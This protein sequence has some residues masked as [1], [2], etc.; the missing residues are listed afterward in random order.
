[1]GPSYAGQY[2]FE[3]VGEP[4]VEE[5]RR[6]A[7]D[8]QIVSPT[9]FETVD[10]PIVAGRGFD[11]RDIRTSNPVC[12]VNEAFVRAYARGRSPIGLRMAVRPANSPQ[13]APVVREVVGVARQVKGRPD[14]PVDLLQIYVP[15]TQSLMDDTYLM[16]RPEAASAEALAPAVRAAIGRVDRDQLVS[17]RDVM[18]LQDVA[19]DATSRHR[20]RA[21]MVMT[22]SALALLLAM[23]G[24]FGILSYS[25]HQRTRDFGVRRA[26]GATTADIFRQTAG[27]ALGVIGAG[28]VIGLLL[29]A[30]LGRLLATMLFGVQP[31]DPATF[32]A[33]SI[34]LTITA[35][36]AAAGPAWRAA[37]VDP[38]RALRGD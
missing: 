11:N 33:V 17:V 6:P 16:V 24:V 7:A 25:V 23:V 31:L 14:E 5:S 30:M 9:Y 10:L 36:A 18:T 19:R 1:M 8:Y 22:F 38:A 35:A 12:L 3:V 13:A 2:A 4:P 37:R 27:S 34:V 26:L 20:F 29:A 21:V 32:A 28:T 15:M